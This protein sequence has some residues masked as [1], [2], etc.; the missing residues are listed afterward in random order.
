MTHLYFEEKLVV[1]CFLV[2]ISHNSHASLQLV[3]GRMFGIHIFDCEL[4]SRELLPSSS[5][6]QLNFSGFLSADG[7]KEHKYLSPQKIIHFY[8]GVIWKMTN[9]YSSFL[10]FVFDEFTDYLI[11][12]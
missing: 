7:S 3:C 8:C 2:S 9:V 11:I 6:L 5:T 12:E 4:S 1:F 10:V